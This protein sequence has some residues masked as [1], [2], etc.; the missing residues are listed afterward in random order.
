[1]VKVLCDRCGA[2]ITNEAYLD[3]GLPIFNISYLFNI[4]YCRAGRTYD[5][6]N[7]ELCKKCNDALYD[8]MGKAEETPEDQIKI[9]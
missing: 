3:N 6:V 8:W 7:I 2:D 4:S 9:D 5:E 1:M